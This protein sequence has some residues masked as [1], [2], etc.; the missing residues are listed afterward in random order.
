MRVSYKGKKFMLTVVKD[1]V[2]MHCINAC[3][4]HWVIN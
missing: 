3:P 2:G 4:S 1:E